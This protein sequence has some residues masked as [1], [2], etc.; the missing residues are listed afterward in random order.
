M[1]IKDI[2][3]IAAGGANICAA[4]GFYRNAVNAIKKIYLP[5]LIN[6]PFSLAGA[7]QLPLSKGSQNRAI[8]KT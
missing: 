6:L 5:A 2:I 7:R 4:R 1:K 3:Q 8:N